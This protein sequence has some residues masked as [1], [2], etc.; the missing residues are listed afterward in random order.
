MPS[1]MEFCDSQLLNQASRLTGDEELMNAERV[2]L[3]A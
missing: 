2:Y 3:E 1:R